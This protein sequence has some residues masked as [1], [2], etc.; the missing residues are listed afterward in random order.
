[1]I[2]LGAL[3]SG[4]PITFNEAGLN[5]A[6]RFIHNANQNDQSFLDAFKMAADHSEMMFR[7]GG[8]F[9]QQL[10]QTNADIASL[11]DRLEAYHAQSRETATSGSR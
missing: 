8:R 3:I 9:L 2:E 4:H 10:Q 5:E 11:R 6:A 1:M 7:V